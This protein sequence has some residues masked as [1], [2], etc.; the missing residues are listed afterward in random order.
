MHADELDIDVGL[1]RRLVAKQFP[2]WSDLPLDAVRPRGTDNALYRLG[3]DK[4]VRLP[5]REGNVGALAKECRWL[6]KLAPLLP[7]PVPVPVAIGK[8]AAGYPFMW[9]VYRWLFGRP[10][11]DTPIADLGRAATELAGF[12]SALEAVDAADG[13]RPGSHNVAR[14][15]PLAR[16]DEATRAAI[17][18]L[19]DS[20]DGDAVTA[21]WEEA[22][23]APA[24]DGPPVW[25]HGDL[26]ARNLLVEHGSLSAVIDFGTLG[27]GDPAYDVM[28]AWKMFPSDTRDDF[29][30]A[31]AVDDATAARARGLAVSQA[32]IALDYY[33]LETNAVLVRESQSWISEVLAESAGSDSKIQGT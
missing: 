29:L 11:T 9:A 32:V 23:D 27:V 17:A 7:L 18:G 26:D 5:R 30:R 16:R 1:V 12:I 25:I 2:E 19:G 14:G 13:P 22:L 8:P 33:T 21:V 31:L 3:D 6:P 24:W 20:I 10:A 4:V 15:S 28:V